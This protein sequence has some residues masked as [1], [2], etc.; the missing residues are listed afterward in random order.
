LKRKISLILIVILILS[1]LCGCKNREPERIT[2]NEWL[3]IQKEHSYVDLEAFCEGMDEVYTLYIIEAI[4]SED[5][6]IELS[7]LN[8]QYNLM[9]S[10]YEELKSKHPLEPESHSV[11]SL[12]G[13][14]AIE[15]MYETIRTT[16][17]S[18]VDAQG[19]PLSTQEIAYLYLAQ[20]Q[21]LQEHIATF[22]NAIALLNASNGI[23]STD[24]STSDEVFTNIN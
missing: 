23:Y 12:D 7:L 16:L 6:K 2:G 14:N 9:L 20:S 19:Q 8:Q 22:T 1:M 4:S 24:T 17:A 18:S 13:T 21:V 11:L 3:M 15:C 10:V 5:F